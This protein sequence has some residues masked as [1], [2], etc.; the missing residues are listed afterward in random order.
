MGIDF[1]YILYGC[2]HASKNTCT[3][4]LLLCCYKN[5]NIGLMGV[6]LVQL[7]VYALLS[8]DK[9]NLATLNVN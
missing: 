5:L 8:D 3:P 2:M 9:R 7:D 6:V 4:R 1:E